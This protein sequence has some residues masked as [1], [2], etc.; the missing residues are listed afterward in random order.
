[1]FGL[2]YKDGV[3]MAAD[4]LGSYGSLTRFSNLPRVIRLNPTTVVACSGDYADFQFLTEVLEQKQIE[5]EMLCGEDGTADTMTPKALHSWLT[6]FLYNKRSRFDPLWTTLIVGG[7]QDGKPYLGYVNMIGVA[8]NEKA[9]ATGIGADLAV[10]IFR[11]FLE[12]KPSS[13]LQPG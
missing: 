9:V 7:L 2:E 6:R 12:K 13:E 8:F 3:V 11:K 5:E 1:M 4:T 10:P